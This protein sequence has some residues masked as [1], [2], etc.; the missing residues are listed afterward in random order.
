MKWEEVQKIMSSDSKVVIHTG[1]SGRGSLR[2]PEMF[3]N[4]F[5]PTEQLKDVIPWKEDRPMCVV[6]LRKGDN[7]R[8]KRRGLEQE[9]FTLMKEKFDRDCYLITNNHEWY[10]TFKDWG[11]PPWTEVKKH[12]MSSSTEVRFT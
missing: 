5:V 10:E 3:A 2:M 12:Q 1:N 7:N 4:V 8:D 11:H 6:H 9:T